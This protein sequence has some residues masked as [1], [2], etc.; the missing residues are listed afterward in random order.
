LRAV[1]G[2]AVEDPDAVA[3]SAEYAAYAIEVLV[4]RLRDWVASVVSGED[5][6]ELVRSQMR[7]GRDDQRTVQQQV[8]D[9]T[10]ECR[11]VLHPAESGRPRRRR[12]PRR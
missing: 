4:R 11:K 6:E 2:V 5:R 7:Y 1:G 12:L 10:A 9:F 8:D 3:H